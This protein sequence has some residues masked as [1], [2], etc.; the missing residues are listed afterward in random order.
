MKF[1]F[2]S[3]VTQPSGGLF[4]NTNRQY[5]HTIEHTVFLFEVNITHSTTYEKKQQHWLK[6]KPK[7]EWRQKFSNFPINHFGKKVR[8]FF[9]PKTKISVEKEFGDFPIFFVFLDRH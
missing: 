4:G 8:T 1:L 7:P 6:Q 9:C 3:L 2:F 5:S